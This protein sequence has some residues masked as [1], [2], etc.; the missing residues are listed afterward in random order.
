MTNHRTGD[1]CTLTFKPRGWRGGNACEIKGK[2][3]DRNGKAQWDVAGKWNSR[4]YARRSAAGQGD[5]ATD[6]TST[7]AAG[8]AAHV[9]LWQNSVKPPGMPFNL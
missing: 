3:I 4:L 8:D 2:V 7:A 1:T 6:V 9:L 5:L